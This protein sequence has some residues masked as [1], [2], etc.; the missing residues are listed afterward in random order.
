MSPAAD[1]QVP[2][3]AFG[4]P[5]MTSDTL[6]GTMR[7]AAQQFCAQGRDGARLSDDARFFCGGNTKLL[8]K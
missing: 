2:R 5:K 8:A 4:V 6:G 7:E 1:G 3:R